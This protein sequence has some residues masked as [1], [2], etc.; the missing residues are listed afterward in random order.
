MER[1]EK[2]KTDIIQALQ[3]NFRLCLF[4][5]LLISFTVACQNGPD[6]ETDTLPGEMEEPPGREFENGEVLVVES[7]EP[8]EPPVALY[9]QD[10]TGLDAWICESLEEAVLAWIDQHFLENPQRGKYDLFYIE[11]IDEDAAVVTVG[12]CCSEPDYTLEYEMIDG[13]WSLSQKRAI[14]HSGYDVIRELGKPLEELLDIFGD[15]NE[16]SAIEDLNNSYY[17]GDYYYFYDHLQTGF[18]VGGEPARVQGVELLG[19]YYCLSIAAGAQPHHLI[20]Q[21]GEP[22]SQG[23][24]EEARRVGYPPYIWFYSLPDIKEHLM[25]V[26]RGEMLDNLLPEFAGK[27]SFYFFSESEESPIE[28]ILAVDSK[29]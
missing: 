12:V 11:T 28:I 29:E 16:A 9:A 27:L 5:V 20:Q 18:M 14:P 25:S 15:P 3:R 19:F 17:H 23:Y 2:H 6:S 13:Q 7:K 24:S 4:M 10:P 26:G 1:Q 21:L 22:S 8:D